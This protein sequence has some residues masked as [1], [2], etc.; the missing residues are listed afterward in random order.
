MNKPFIDAIER[1]KEITVSVDYYGLFPLCGLQ[2]LIQKI[3]RERNVD[4]VNWLLD[5]HIITM[6]IILH[7]EK[8]NIYISLIDYR[9]L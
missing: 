1:D 7:I 3:Q 8:E 5:G 9:I 4:L 2:N 6:K